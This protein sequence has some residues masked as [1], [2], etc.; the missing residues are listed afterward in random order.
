MNSTVLDRTPDPGVIGFW[1]TAQGVTLVTTAALIVA[2]FIVPETALTVLW[3]VAIPLLPAVF[4]VDPGLWRNICP[5]ATIN[6]L[7]NRW[8]ARRVLDDRLVP[9][10]GVIGIVLLALMV[11]AR[12]FVFNT[13]GTGLAVTIMLVAALAFVLGAVFDKKAG[14]CS[15]ICPVLAVERLYGQSP[16]LDARNPR[17]APCTMCITRGCLDIAQSKS[18]VQILGR[19]R[20]SHAWLQSGYGVF[21]A[22]FP[23]FVIGYNLTH[24]G[25]LGTAGSVYLTVAAWTAGGY[26]TSQL[27]VRGLNLSAALAMRLLAAL[28]IGLYYWFVA[29]VGTDHLALPGPAPTVIRT[30]AFALVALWLWRAD[31]S[32]AAHGRDA[33]PRLP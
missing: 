29:G 27:L 26:L 19:A 16:L 11:P 6:M 15:S 3:D 14:F 21:A 25:A 2:L 1:R 7:P 31:W 9:A 24:D 10:A 32:L 13:D 23:G 20:R 17:C 5:L 28:A 30:V 4:L 18:I 22:G 12:R 33:S 8:G